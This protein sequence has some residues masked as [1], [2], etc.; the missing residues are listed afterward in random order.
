MTNLR[1]ESGPVDCDL[2]HQFVSSV[3]WQFNYC[4]GENSWERRFMNGWAFSTIV[5]VQ[6]GFLF[7]IYNGSDANLSGNA[8]AGA[9]APTSG[10]RAELVP[11]VNPVL[12]NRN[13]QEWFNRP[14][15]SRM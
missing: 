7:T 15:S 3:V 10:E 2:R 1:L 13:A 9:F 6:S 4:H 14:R 11:G 5:N 8:T 12:S